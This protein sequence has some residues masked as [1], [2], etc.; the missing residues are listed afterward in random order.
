VH[1][2]WSI[3]MEI[4]HTTA[5]QQLPSFAHDLRT[6][7]DTLTA[8]AESAKAAEATQTDPATAAS[9]QAP[10][11]PPPTGDAAPAAG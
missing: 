2:Y 9:Q 6:V 1:G 5:T 11:P 4:L 8:D 7:L 10:D 3:D